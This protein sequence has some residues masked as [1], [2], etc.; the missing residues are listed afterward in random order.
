MPLEDQQIPEDP[1]R[2]YRRFGW[3][4]Q[5]EFFLL[6]G[7]QY[8]EPSAEATCGSNPD[9]LGTLAG[10]LLADPV[11]TQALSQERSLLG[12]EQ[13]DWLTTGLAE[14]TA[15][16]KVVVND[17]PFSYVGVLPYDRWDGY[18]AER[19]A[20]LEFINAQEIGGV[21]FLTTDFHSSWYN[22][23]VTGYFRDRRPDYEL[24][25]D[26]PVAEAIVGPIGVATLHESVLRLVADALG[27]PTGPLLRSL[28]TGLER[29]V[30]RRL[31]CAGGFTLAETNRISYV[32]VD[33][34]PS[35]EVEINYRGVSP[36]DAQDPDTA[37][38]TFYTTSDEASPSLP[39][40]LPVL[41]LMFGGSL[42][43]KDLFGFLNPLGQ[44][45]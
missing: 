11:C 44:H 41:L 16:V 34:S 7:R 40:C 38:E 37:V 13:F 39:C 26:V 15:A 4:S 18:D 3:G 28:L 5:V 9:P 8:R 6:D 45:F 23:D 36:D 30:T 21:L 17:V 19:R 33:V 22:P 12:Q 25:N 1:F 14:S 29:C 42:L 43:A 10:P 27:R 20:L 2:T 24:P 35:G 32:V 31:Q